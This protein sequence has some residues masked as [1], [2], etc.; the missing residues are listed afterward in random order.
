M[1]E[2]KNFDA[3]G[4]YAASIESVPHMATTRGAFPHVVRPRNPFA[5][6]TVNFHFLSSKLSRSPNF[7]E[8]QACHQFVELLGKFIDLVYDDS[9]LEY[10]IDIVRLDSYANCLDS[11]SL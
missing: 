2:F 7:A 1:R 6:G 11:A 9:L 5:S 8:K 4:A 3:C 10:L